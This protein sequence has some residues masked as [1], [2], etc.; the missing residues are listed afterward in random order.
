[1]HLLELLF[2]LLE[3][4]K[5]FLPSLNLYLPV[6]HSLFITYWF[7]FGLLDL[8]YCLVNVL[9]FFPYLVNCLECSFT[10]LRNEFVQAVYVFKT[11]VINRMVNELHEIKKINKISIFKSNC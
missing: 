9:N 4:S 5:L 11:F 7:V 10:S 8:N 6:F 2:M 1:V 3:L